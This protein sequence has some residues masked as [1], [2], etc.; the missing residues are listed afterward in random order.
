MQEIQYRY[1]Q[2]SIYTMKHFLCAKYAFLGFEGISYPL[3]P[4][5]LTL[6]FKNLKL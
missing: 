4:T 1:V 2:I 5:A 3:F 6:E